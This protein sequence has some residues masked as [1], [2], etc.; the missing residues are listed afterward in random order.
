MPKKNLI[1]QMLEKVNWAD[2]LNVL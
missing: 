2:G 1:K